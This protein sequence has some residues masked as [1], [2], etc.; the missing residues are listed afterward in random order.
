MGG[1]GSRLLMAEPSCCF[2]RYLQRPHHK[3]LICISGTK[4]KISGNRSYLRWTIIERDR[5]CI[6]I[7]AVC[8]HC[9]SDT[10]WRW[11]ISCQVIVREQC[12]IDHGAIES[13]W[14]HGRGWKGTRGGCAARGRIVASL[15]QVVVGVIVLT[16]TKVDTDGSAS[17][18]ED[19]NG[20]DQDLVLGL[21][22]LLFRDHVGMYVVRWKT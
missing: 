18:D 15:A 21:H 7:S 13:W 1:G 10:H 4:E 12:A 9:A 20:S 3:N 17:E 8:V 22:W 5:E 2:P 6:V 14:G 11:S 19:C 16:D